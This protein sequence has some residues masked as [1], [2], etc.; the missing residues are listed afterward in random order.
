MVGI[1]TAARAQ[2]II[3]T[4]D[5]VP[6]DADDFD[7]VAGLGLPRVTVASRT[8][9]PVIPTTDNPV[10]IVFLFELIEFLTSAVVVPALVTVYTVLMPDESPCRFRLSPTS[11]SRRRVDGNVE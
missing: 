10:T 7:A 9:V 1:I 2:I 3:A 4:C 5:D 6:L 8:D 11:I